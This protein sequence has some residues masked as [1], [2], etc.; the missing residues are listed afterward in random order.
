MMS[1]MNETESP[2][3]H[4]AAP[5][6]GD[7]ATGLDAAGPSSEEKTLGMLC[8]LMAFCGYVIPFGNLLG[9][10]VIW[11]TKKDASPFVD[12]QGKESLNFQITVSIACIVCIPLI[13]IASASCC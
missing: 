8:H 3:E 13:F 5:P 10:L 1:P 7:A 11:L 6:A 4:S 9:P 2:G 12:D